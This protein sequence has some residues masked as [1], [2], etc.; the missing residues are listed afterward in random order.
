MWSNFRYFGELFFI[1]QQQQYILIKAKYGTEA[2]DVG[3]FFG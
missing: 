2:S 3:L 1:L